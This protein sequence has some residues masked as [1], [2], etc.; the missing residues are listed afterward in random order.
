M[1]FEGTSVVQVVVSATSTDI[2]Y[3]SVVTVRPPSR[4]LSFPTL[5]TNIIAEL[6]STDRSTCPQVT[7]PVYQTVINT[8]TATVIDDVIGRPHEQTPVP[9]M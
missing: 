2:I 4:P 3:T 1:V 7:I 8:V 9:F 5:C 6:S